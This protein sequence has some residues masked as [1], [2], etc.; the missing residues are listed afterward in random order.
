MI[1]I[2][3]LHVRPLMWQCLAGRRDNDNLENDYTEEHIPRSI[4]G[5]GNGD[6]NDSDKRGM[7]D[8]LPVIRLVTLEALL[9]GCPTI[10]D[11]HSSRANWLSILISILS[12]YSTIFSGIWLMLAMVQPRY[13]R[14]IHSGGSLSQAPLRLL[15]SLH[16]A[17]K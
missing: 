2:R 10:H 8:S 16:Y 3:D 1:R 6:D 5:N 4:N 12:I 9:K 17:L 13:S 11:I 14:T 15:H 7:F